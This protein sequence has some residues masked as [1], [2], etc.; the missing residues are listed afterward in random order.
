MPFQRGRSGNPAGKPK[1]ALRKATAEREAKIAASGLTPLDY[2]LSVLRDENQPPERRDEM[3]KAAAP[4]V[5][6]KLSAI[7]ARVDQELNATIESPQA[8]DPSKLTPNQRDVLKEILLAAMS[9]AGAP[10]V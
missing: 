7:N 2:M 3:A 1:G 8:I 5:H 4:Y 9:E 10:P 6:P